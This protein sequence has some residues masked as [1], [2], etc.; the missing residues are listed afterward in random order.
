[1]S[2]CH[3]ELTDLDWNLFEGKFNILRTDVVEVPNI[4]RHIC[5]LFVLK[6]DLNLWN[7]KKANKEK[8]MN[9]EINYYEI[10]DKKIWYKSTLKN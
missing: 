1:M 5:R 7:E 8:C 6:I 9:V 2:H 3:I 10:T 4:F